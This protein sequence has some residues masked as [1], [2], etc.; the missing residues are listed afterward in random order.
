MTLFTKT[1]VLAALV[2]IPSAALAGG[3]GTAGVKDARVG[4]SPTQTAVIWCPKLKTEVPLALSQQMDCS[5]GVAVGTA[6]PA[7]ARERFGGRGLFGLPPHQP[8]APRS[9]LDKEYTPVA[10][11]DP[12]GRPNDEPPGGEQEPPSNEPSGNDTPKET[13][14][15]KTKWERLADFGVTPENLQSQPRDFKTSVKDYLKDH[16]PRTD[17]SGFDPSSGGTVQQ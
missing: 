1:A 7:V 8:Q 13:G 11:N 5:D 10:D 4:Q 3:Y 15:I 9:A 14:G 6:Q 16:G 17:W 2:A 12:P